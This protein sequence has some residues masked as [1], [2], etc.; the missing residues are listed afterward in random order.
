MKL[1]AIKME[2][3]LEGLKSKAITTVVTTVEEKPN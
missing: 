3:D 1:A 2:N